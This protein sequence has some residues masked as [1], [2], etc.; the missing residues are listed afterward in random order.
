M[1]VQNLLHTQPRTDSRPAAG[2]S[3]AAGASFQEKLVQTSAVVEAPPIHLR[4]PTENTVYSGAHAGRNNT[5][6][7]IYA[8]YAADST[9]ED[10]IVSDQRSVSNPDSTL[11]LKMASGIDKYIFSN[12]NIFPK[13]V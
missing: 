13:S 2:R 3:R 6:Q 1:S 12:D 11:I 4:M 7:E 10:H 8:E 9:P 5:M